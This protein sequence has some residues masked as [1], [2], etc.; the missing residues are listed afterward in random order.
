MFDCAAAEPAFLPFAQSEAY[1]HAAS[2]C[3]AR[4]ISADLGC[5]TALIVERGRMRLISCGPVWTGGT[6]ADQRLALRRLARWPGLTV[7]TPEA[8]MAGFG[9]I[10]LVTPAHHALWDIGPDAVALRARLAGNWRNRLVA[11]ERSGL[12]IQRGGGKDWAALIAA[13]T[14]QRVTRG[15]RALP[16]A[17]S[18]ALPDTAR[19]I[20]VWRQGGRMQAAMGFVRHGAVASYHL[21]WA[22]VAA[23][24]AGVHGVMLWKAVLALREEGV[25]W[26]DLGLVNDAVAP[27]LAHFKRGTGA[28]VRS[29]G[30]TMLVLPR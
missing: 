30:A 11:A 13:E 18:A 5:G 28:V 21:G 4:V 17:F 24:S 15:Y 22:D 19:R 7:A 12:R 26:I 20:W 1:A 9:L 29:L 23:R 2:R 8:G 3:G 14:G 27:G 6:A 25:R 16:P 10:P